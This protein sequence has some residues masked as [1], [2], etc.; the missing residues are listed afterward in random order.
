VPKGTVD[1]QEAP[2][3]SERL[4]EE[5]R[6]LEI[7]A[8]TV[9]RRQGE[10]DALLELRDRLG[11]ELEGLERQG[12]DVRPE[13]T[14]LE[15]IDGY[16]RANAGTIVRQFRKV[17]GM[18]A[19]RER[20]QPPEEHWWW[21]LDVY[22]SSRIR[23]T[24]TRWV[25]ITLVVVAVVLVGDYL[26]T[27]YF[28]PSPEEAAANERTMAAERLVSEGEYEQAL[29][30][31]EAAA[32]IVPDDLVTQCMLGVLYEM[33]GRFE[34]SAVARAKAEKLSEGRASY[35]AQLSRAYLFVQN[36]KRGLET[37]MEAIDADPESAF[38]YFVL[39]E[40][41]ERRDRVA[42]AVQAFDVSAQLAQ[43]Q[44]NDVLYALAREREAMLVS[45]GQ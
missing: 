20:V 23:R 11:S 5:L 45:G 35:L 30:E 17:G 40:A 25:T 32:A 24:V 15:T 21:W 26:L 28:G 14:R 39:G 10:I 22:R 12:L 29:A 1:G 18:A 27:K 31:Y 44:G 8:A 9:R 2:R 7:Q 4:R 13:R 34:E 41:Y 19:A 43:E 38:A 36:T 3:A 37:A 42:L 16:L 6:L 33:E